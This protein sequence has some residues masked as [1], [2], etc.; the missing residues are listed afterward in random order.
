MLVHVDARPE[1]EPAK[2]LAMPLQTYL[3]STP[4]LLTKQRHSVPHEK[5]QW[6]DWWARRC[7]ID[8]CFVSNLHGLHGF[9][10]ALCT[11]YV[12]AW[13]QRQLRRWSRDG[14]QHRSWLTRCLYLVCVSCKIVNDE[15]QT[16]SAVKLALNAAW[17]FTI[18]PVARFC[19]IPGMTGT[20]ASREADSCQVHMHNICGECILLLLLSWWCWDWWC[21]LNYETIVIMN[22]VQVV[23]DGKQ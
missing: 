8:G 4:W 15:H 12:K 3:K 19:R 18:Q 21:K 7:L 2:V 23:V 1:P 11:E 22:D 17:P 5:L 16:A 10:Q 13:S 9:R 6:A 14:K 20:S